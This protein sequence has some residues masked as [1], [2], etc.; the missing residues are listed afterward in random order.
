[1]KAISH[2]TKHK[3]A[4]STRPKPRLQTATDA[5]DQA[6]S[7]EKAT[8]VL[9]NRLRVLNSTGHLGIIGV[10]LAPD[11]GAE[12]DQSKQGIF[13]ISVA[14]VFDTPVTIESGQAPLCAT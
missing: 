4:V 14:E 1:M 2:Q 10:Y 13:R 11:P 7:K 6:P 9:E 5:L 8:Q 12:N 3:M